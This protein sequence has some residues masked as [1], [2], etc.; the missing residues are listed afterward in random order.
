MDIYEQ[1]ADF[2]SKLPG[3]N[4]WDEMTA[5]FLR[6]ASHKPHH[7]LLPVKA[8]EA[9]GGMPEGAVPAAVAIASS[10]ISIIL[11]DDMLDSDPR[12]EY[13]RIGA[14]AAANLACAFQAAS[15]EAIARSER[16][17]LVLL[18]AIASFNRMYLMTALGQSLDVQCPADEEAYWHIVQTKSSPF[19]G[20]ALYIG[21][22]L[23]GASVETAE[24]SGL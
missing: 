17:S 12:G 16:E 21:A 15:L 13:Q 20:A 3:S 23:G 1:I 8:C 11:V 19:F 2:F 7:W 4:A 5:L 6:L 9:V 10:H 24:R 22:L 18:L 14:P